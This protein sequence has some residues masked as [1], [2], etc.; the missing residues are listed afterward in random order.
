MDPIDPHHR[1]RPST[2]HHERVVGHHLMKPT[3]LVAERAS[4][5]ADASTDLTVPADL[6][7]AAVVSVS[8]AR[9]ESANLKA[10]GST[11]TVDR[12]VNQLQ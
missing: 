7:V 11:G 5:M 8:A 1:L 4:A 2:R 6:R 10:T 9:S 12:T 3:V